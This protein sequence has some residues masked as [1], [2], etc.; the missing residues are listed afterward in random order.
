MKATKHGP[1]LALILAAQAVCAW[2]NEESFSFLIRGTG[3]RTACG[4]RSQCN[5]APLMRVG[6]PR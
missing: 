1:V 5:V 2:A 6:A 4:L 3:C